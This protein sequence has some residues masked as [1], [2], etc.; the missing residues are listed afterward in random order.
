MRNDRP[1][2]KGLTWTA[3]GFVAGLA[4]MLAW[5]AYRASQGE[6]GD[7]ALDAQA[8]HQDAR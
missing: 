8:R 1:V 2:L 7:E 3:I 5:N 4:L 6:P